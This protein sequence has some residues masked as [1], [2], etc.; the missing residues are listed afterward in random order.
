MFSGTMTDY[1]CVFYCCGSLMKKYFSCYTSVMSV[2]QASLSRRTLLSSLCANVCLCIALCSP[3]TALANAYDIE[4]FDPEEIGRAELEAVTLDK[5]YKLSFS[6]IKQLPFLGLS[7][8]AWDEQSHILYAISDRGVLFHFKLQFD[9]NDVLKAVDLLTAYPLRDDAGKPLKGRAA[10]SEGLILHHITDDLFQAKTPTPNKPASQL[11]PPQ[12]LNTTTA[13]PLDTHTSTAPRLPAQ[14]EL[15][16]SFEHQPR[17]VRYS[18]TGDYLGEVPLPNPLKN[19][20]HYRH[21]NKALESLTFHPIFGVLTSAEYSL[22]A[23]SRDEQHIYNLRGNAMC[24]IPAGSAENSAITALETMPDGSVL[25]L[26]RSWVS[27]GKP[28]VITLRKVSFP[29]KQFANCREKL[30]A[31]LSSA[32]GW[33][34]DN[35]EGL[36]HIGRNRYLMVSDDN[37][38]PLQQTLLVQFS[39]KK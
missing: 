19:I 7:G 4:L 2:I 15:L 36:T 22:K 25:V 8:L 5:G 28:L 38:N 13:Q 37:N 21:P 26:E 31:T 32:D 20:N 18:L 14:K 27:I 24:H 35:F 6:S 1:C 23:Y 12:V 9:N 11:P 16:V 39:V 17:I 33:N 29:K 34:V 3:I 10:D 30:L